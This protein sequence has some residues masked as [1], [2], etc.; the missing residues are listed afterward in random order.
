MSEWARER[1]VEGVAAWNTFGL[2]PLLVALAVWRWRSEG[3]LGA[4]ARGAGRLGLIHLGLAAWSLTRVVDE[5]WAYRAMG[6]LPSNPLTGLAG[7]LLAISLDLPL[8]LGL[9]N[10]RRWSRRLGLAV[11]VGRVAIGAFVLRWTWNHGA[12][13]DLTE[14][15][16]LA[17]SYGLPLLGLV[18]LAWPGMAGV[19]RG[20]REEGSDSRGA[21]ALAVTSLLALVVLGSVVLTD[22]ADWALRAGTSDLE[23]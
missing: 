13:V 8:G 14:W 23:S 9:W 7:S 11:T 18:A 10:L 5:L 15:P 1:F 16:R 20:E 21:K 4:L 22:A 6:I 12:V 2:P 3:S 19:F 17:L